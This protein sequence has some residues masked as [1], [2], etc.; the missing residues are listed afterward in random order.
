MCGIVGKVSVGGVVERDLVV[1]MCEV[2]RHRGPDSRGVFVDGGV[3]LGVQRL[4]VIDLETGD[5]PIFNEDRSVV[6]V[7][8][9]EIYNFVE[10]AEGLRRRGH[11]LASR[12]DTEVIVHLYEEHGAGCVR[13][14]RGMFAFALWDRRRQCLL[15]ARDRVGKKPLFYAQRGGELWFGSEA[16]S[17]LQDGA[18]AR[19]PDL[20]A[21]D[22]FLHF[23]YV[24]DPLSAFEGLRKLPPAHTL[25]WRDG[26]SELSRYWKLSYRRGRVASRG[27]A[28]EL[29]RERLLE[30]TRIRMRSDVPL[31]AFLSG[32]VD[33]SAVVA[34]MARLASGQVKTFSIGFDVS[35]YD[36]TAHAREVAALYGTDHHQLRVEPSALEVLPRLVWHYGEPFA[37]HSAIPSFYLA[38][39][40]RGHVTVALNGDGGDENFAGYYR[41]LR[42]NRSERLAALPRPARLLL[43]TIAAAIGPNQH[44]TSFRTRLDRVT[45][46]AMQ[47]FHARYATYA[48]FFNEYERGGLYTREFAAAVGEGVVAGVMRDPYL[49]SDAEQEL[50]RLLDTDLQ[51][52]L[53]GDLLVKMD[54]ASMAH[55]LEV[56]SPLLDHELMELAASLPA[57]WKIEGLTT[58]KIF[59]EALRPWL[60]K[61]ILDRPKQGFGV[62]LAHWLRGQLRNLP[63]QILLDPTSLKRGWFREQTIR[64]IITDHHNGRRDNTNQIWA[65][66]Q[67][68]LWL[69]TFIDNQPTTPT[70]IDAAGRATV[71]SWQ[72]H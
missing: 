22:A 8:N 63:E 3:G 32:G 44:E 16:K 52:Y 59:K 64:Q 15:L 27:E 56:R 38:Q 48:A 72:A 54:I 46:T 36:E 29:I 12:S 13:F 65:L 45:R 17:I 47:P 53:P 35:A 57:D 33:S 26:R 62:P 60:P 28:Q 43:R 11:V 42:R 5:Q 31:G 19:R 7:L 20:Q 49:A 30:A 51:T 9:G 66:I 23:Q 58:K 68:E 4:R 10:L 25:L 39:L 18:V 6:V 40:T 21:I 69:R 50:D 71:P 67:L 34:A 55:S 61:Q 70:T 41:Y 2:V 1:G 37:D 24:P 14:L